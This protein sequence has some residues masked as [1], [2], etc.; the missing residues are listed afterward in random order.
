V[1]AVREP[2]MKRHAY[3]RDERRPTF[4]QLYKALEPLF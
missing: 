4:T 1:V 2:D 3:Y